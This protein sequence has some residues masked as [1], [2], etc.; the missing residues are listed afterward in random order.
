MSRGGL[1]TWG[2]MT[3]GNMLAVIHVM[4]ILAMSL[5]V[6]KVRATIGVIVVPITMTA[7]PAIAPPP[8]VIP[9]VAWP[10]AAGP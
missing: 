5:V 3:G 10:V 7:V 8:A 6:R 2:V 1:V 9:V 4:G